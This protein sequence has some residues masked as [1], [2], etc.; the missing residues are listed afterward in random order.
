MLLKEDVLIR[1]DIIVLSMLD[2]IIR[3]ISNMALTV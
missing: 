1:A 3:V 2:I